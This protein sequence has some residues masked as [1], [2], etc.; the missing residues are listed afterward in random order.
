MT[1]KASSTRRSFIRKTGAALSM[2][3]AAAAAAVPV[4][5]APDDPAASRIAMLED[6]E[7][8]RVLNQAF[9][10]QVNAGDA[11]SLGID[12]SIRSISAQEFG[13]RDVIEILPDGL[14]AKSL[15]HC[16]VEI[17]TAIGPSCPLVE[18]ARE[19]G[20]GVVKRSETGVFENTCVK[21][22]GIWTIER[23]AYR[24]S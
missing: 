16:I 20:G 13:T 2:P 11:G 15:L 14:A 4:S 19:Q 23:A 5:A 18:M 1:T 7:A 17:E 24:S 6:L 8:I 3:L 22:D 12:S 9:A 10:R 21:R